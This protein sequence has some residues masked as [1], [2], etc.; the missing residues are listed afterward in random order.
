MASKDMKL[1]NVKAGQLFLQNLERTAASP[2]SSVGAVL[3]CVSD[4]WWMISFCTLYDMIGSS[5]LLECDGAEIIC[6]AW[7]SK[8]LVA[9]T[10]TIHR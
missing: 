4:R 8:T 3:K 1:L 7:A 9:G 10:A 5:V 6:K 2:P